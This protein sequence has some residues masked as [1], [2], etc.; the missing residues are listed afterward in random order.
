MSD[1]DLLAKLRE[2]SIVTV[3]DGNADSDQASTFIRNT[4]DTTCMANRPNYSNIS[5][6]GVQSAFGTSNPR[7]IRTGASKKPP[8]PVIDLNTVICQSGMTLR[9]YISSSI[10]NSE[11]SILKGFENWLSE[12]VPQHIQKTLLAIKQSE[13]TM[14]CVDVM[15]CC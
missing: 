14:M 5:V 2:L 3:A 11:A 6:A 9:D 13:T 12:A 8:K 10:G 15:F 4:N 1:D 7:H